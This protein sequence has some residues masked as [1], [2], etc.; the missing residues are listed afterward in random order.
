MEI[1]EEYFYPMLAT[2]KQLEELK[3]RVCKN[4]MVADHQ[5]CLFCPFSIVGHDDN[6]ICTI[7]H[8][9]DKLDGMVERGE[10]LSQKLLE[11]LKEV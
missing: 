7:Q 6:E 2:K 9:I 5:W 10:E 4:T 1:G 8:T 11:V 3:S